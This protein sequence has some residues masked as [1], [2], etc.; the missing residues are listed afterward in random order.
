MPIGK[1][2]NVMLFVVPLLVYYFCCFTIVLGM[3]VKLRG[4]FLFRDCGT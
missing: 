3:L 1:W 2:A 4:I